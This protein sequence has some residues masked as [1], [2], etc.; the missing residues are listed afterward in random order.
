M[1]YLVNAIIIL[2]SLGIAVLI[3]ASSLGVGTYTVLILIDYVLI[4]CLNGD[5]RKTVRN[6]FIGNKIFGSGNKVYGELHLET[7]QEEIERMEPIPFEHFVS[8]LFAKL[9]YKTKITAGKKEF[10]GDVIAKKEEKII[11]IQVKH[12]NSS[13]WLVSNDAVQQAV[14]AMPVHKANKSMVVTNGEFMEN[15]YNQARFSQTVMIDGKQL[16]NLVRQVMAKESSD[17]NQKREH[18]S[19]EEERQKN[20]QNIAENKIAEVL[21]FTA[22]NME[23]TEADCLEIQ[24]EIVLADTIPEV[25]LEKRLEADKSENTPNEE[26]LQIKNKH[27][28]QKCVEESEEVKSDEQSCTKE[29]KA[30]ASQQSDA[31]NS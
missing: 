16:L 30:K 21:E 9:G 12:R 3:A 26:Y 6:H 18:T 23:I 15:A 24:R 19:S 13:D 27:E 29:E 25:I 14:A 10:G 17:G 8:D 2:F 22:E 1:R 31:S 7:L 11:V 28:E 20:T 4:L 5:F